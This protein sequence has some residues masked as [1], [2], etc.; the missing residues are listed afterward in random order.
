V[1]E[2]PTEDERRLEARRSAFL[3]LGFSAREADDLARSDVAYLD[4]RALLGQGFPPEVCA[5]MLREG[6]RSVF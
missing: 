3:R 6:R 1:D 5:A 4:A 2:S